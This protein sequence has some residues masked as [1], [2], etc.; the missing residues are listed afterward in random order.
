MNWLAKTLSDDRLC[1]II[2]ADFRQF[3][4]ADLRDFWRSGSGMTY[5]WVASHILQLPEESRYVKHIRRED[6]RI[7]D[8]DD[9]HRQ[10]MVDLLSLAVYYLQTDALKGMKS[11]Q[12][13]TIQKGAPKRQPR[14]GEEKEKPRMSSKQEINAFFKNL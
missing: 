6:G 9:H 11:S 10:D 4:G 5:R 14:P 1:R 7:W 3:Y 13:A 8:Q 2:E 12:Q